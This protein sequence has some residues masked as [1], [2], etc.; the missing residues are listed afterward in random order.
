MGVLR[1]CIGRGMS[2]SCGRGLTMEFDVRT[3]TLALNTF[4]FSPIEI[5]VS[6]FVS[7]ECLRNERTYNM[8]CNRR[9]E[10][11]KSHIGRTLVSRSL[12]GRR[13]LYLCDGYSVRLWLEV[14][15]LRG[16]C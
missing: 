3:P 12:H 9:T 11:S 10:D 8:G 1:E 5:Q 16:I 13:P 7:I 2:G 15:L 6:L 4:C 14:F